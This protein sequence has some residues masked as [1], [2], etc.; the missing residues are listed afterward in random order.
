MKTM[1]TVIIAAIA[2]HAANAELSFTELQELTPTTESYAGSVTADGQMAVG[3][4]GDEPAM[5]A[6]SVV[7]TNG[8][9]GSLGLRA[10]G[11]ANFAEAIA[12]DGSAIAVTEFDFEFGRRPFRWTEELGFEYLGDLSNGQYGGFPTAVA[13]GGDIIVGV[14]ENGSRDERG[15]IWYADGAPG[16]KARGKGGGKGGKGGGGADP[17]P[18]IGGMISLEPIGGLQHSEAMDISPDGTIVVGAMF[19]GKGTPSAFRWTESTGMV[20]LGP[21]HPNGNG[22]SFAHAISDDGT[23]IIGFGGNIG[24]NEGFRWTEANGMESLGKLDPNEASIPFDVSGDGNV[25]VGYATDFAMVW[26]PTHGIRP[27]S[28]ILEP[29]GTPFA[30]YVRT[31]ALGVSADGR[32]IVGE[33]EKIGGEQRAWMVVIPA[34]CPGD[35]NGDEQVNFDDLNAVLGNWNTTNMAGDTNN[36]DLV[37]FDDLNLV[38]SN[39]GADCR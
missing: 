15:F 17:G 11:T 37:N 33:G 25:I 27:L 34:Y 39:W 24:G 16:G 9:L 13:N 18:A 36:D 5:T 21:A 20:A 22:N 10:A 6:E 7:W 14:A 28:K 23:T 1:T 35:V 30:D 12:P 8:L 29:I 3:G 4:A 32:V 38:L 2:G 26:T 31:N 19:G